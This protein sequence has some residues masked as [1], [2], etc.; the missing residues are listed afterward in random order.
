MT[1]QR[2]PFRWVLGRA[3]L[4]WLSALT[5]VVALAA[6]PASATPEGD[7]DVAITDA[8]NAAGGPTSPLGERDGG[9]YAVGGG[10]GQNFVGGAI[11]YTPATGAHTMFG[12]IL[13]RYRA[14][15]GP[16]D[17]GLG[18]PTVDEGP[19]R[20]S[21]ESRNSIF[22]AADN[23]VIFW[24]PESGAWV[25]R[26]AMNAAWDHLGGSSG[27][28]GV[29][30]EDETY[31]GSVITQRFS[32]GLVSYD[33]ATGTFTTEPGDLAGQLVGLPIPGD[34]TTAINT[35]YR[36]AGGAEGPLGAREG[37][38]YAVGDDG[39]AQNF[40]GGKIFYTPGTGARALTGAVLERY[41]SAGGPTGEL[42]F[43]TSGEV[44]GGVPDSRQA[45]FAAADHP[46][47]FWTQ[48]NGAI[49]VNGPVK[50]A[51]DKLGGP[52]GA[53]GVPTAEHKI[54]GDVMSQKFT[55]GEVSWNAGDRTFTTSP[56]ELA[57]ALEGIE[58]PNQPLPSVQSSDQPGGSASGEDTGSGG[59]GWLWWLLPVLLLLG[60]GAWLFTRRRSTPAVDAEG[61]RYEG[62][63]ARYADDA[64]RYDED[65]PRYDEDAPRY[66][67]DAPP[68]RTPRLQRRRFRRRR[69]PLLLRVR[70]RPGLHRGT[71][72][73]DRRRP[74]G[75][76]P[77]GHPR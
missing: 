29:P 40:A 30:I 6:A 68:T 50:A 24:T 47:I 38:Q 55:G 27:V 54:D 44:D 64:P 7:A 63:A 65:A 8:W 17:S 77:G 33:T 75:D 57:D 12:A 22:S 25:V 2:N 21:P 43:P 51:W 13:D 42:G 16:A 72:R 20:V 49:V 73:V 11:F 66:D 9:V 28:L 15:G 32:A 69:G 58:V 62:D 19:G 37:E 70:Q 46:V 41:E 74:R 14:L 18:F 35:A 31:N 60:L 61:G 56:P 5:L 71:H 1:R 39:V 67:E 45:S 10:F 76:H 48:D 34:A 53:L 36:T 52:T 59:A 23:P 26:G 4:A 3:L